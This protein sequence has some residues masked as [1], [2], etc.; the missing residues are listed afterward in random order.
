MTEHENSIYWCGKLP[1]NNIV[2]GS[3][4]GTLKIWNI[5]TDIN[6][7]LQGKCELTLKHPYCVLLCN[8][9]PD[10]RIVSGSHDGIIKIWS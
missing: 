7:N 2:I 4:D 10:G 1:N 9:L 5:Q 8:I 6:G 3:D